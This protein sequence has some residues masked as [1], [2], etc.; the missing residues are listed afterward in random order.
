MIRYIEW[1]KEIHACSHFLYQLTI[2]MNCVSN[3]PD[4]FFLSSS[5]T[6]LPLDAKNCSLVK[7]LVVTIQEAESI[8]DQLLR[9]LFY[10]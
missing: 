2:S 5:N 1:F 7:F 4:I 10:T 3:K 8:I 6:I 9:S